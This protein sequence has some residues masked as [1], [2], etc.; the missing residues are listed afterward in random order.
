MT[1]AD[2]RALA[3]STPPAALAV[4]A[5]GGIVLAVAAVLSNDPAGRLLIAF[6]ALALLVMAG[7]GL[8]QRP[9]LAIEPGTAQPIVV[10]G[11]AGAKRFGPDEILRARIVNYRRLGR[12]VPM[13]ELD[14]NEHGDERLL[15]FGRWDLGAH[16]QDVFETLQA[17]LPR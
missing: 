4:C 15:I 11:V 12:K 3:W 17:Y 5:L 10:R 8:R 1:P 14:V 13:L 2:A 6:A 16:P 9:R 7:V